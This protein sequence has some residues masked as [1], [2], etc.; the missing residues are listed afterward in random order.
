MWKETVVACFK[1]LCWHHLGCNM[2]EIKRQAQ[3]KKMRPLS[4]EMLSGLSHGHLFSK[5]VKKLLQNF[6]KGSFIHCYILFCCPLY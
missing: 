5:K 3:V 2:V 6:L 1:I 4:S